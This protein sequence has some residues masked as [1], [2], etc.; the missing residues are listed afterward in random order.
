[1]PEQI[2]KAAFLAGVRCLTEG[3]RTL[4]SERESV[5]PA[6]E[7]R[8]LV[9]REIGERAQRQLGP[10]RQL[11]RSPTDRAAAE[12]RAA[13]AEPGS[14]LLFEATLLDSRFVARADALT[15]TSAG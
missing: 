5:T 15:K 8:L 14:K 11:L 9:G 4:R 6:V 3:W 1:M 13:L 7:W 10:G 12:T 2:T